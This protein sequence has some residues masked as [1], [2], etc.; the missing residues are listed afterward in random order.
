MSEV[1]NVIREDELTCATCKVLFAAAANAGTDVIKYK[2][3]C[4]ELKKGLRQV[5]ALTGLAVE[6]VEKLKVLAEEEEKEDD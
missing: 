5:W 1:S 6:L 3:R 4:K 2:A